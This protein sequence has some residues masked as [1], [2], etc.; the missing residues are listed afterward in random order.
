LTN[1]ALLFQAQN[2]FDNARLLCQR[3][4]AIREKVLG[5]EHPSTA[6]SLNDLGNLLWEYRQPGA[7]PLFE[8]AL[9]ICEKMFGPTHPSTAISLYGLA[10]LLRK[11]GNHAAA[12]QFFE[13]V[14]TIRKRA[15]G[16]KHP[17]T[18]AVR[19]ILAK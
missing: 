16:S 6:T 8:R 19:N 15:L 9:A 18:A 5:P 2:D 3:A 10:N 11:E 12:R 4:L 17:A 14:L 1:L 13:R 7:R